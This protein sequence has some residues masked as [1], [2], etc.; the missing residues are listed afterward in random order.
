MLFLRR[1]IVC[2]IGD[3]LNIRCL[4]E[5]GFARQCDCL[6]GARR[7]L[8]FYI[9]NGLPHFSSPS[10]KIPQ[11]KLVFRVHAR[12]VLQ[13]IQS[14]LRIAPLQISSVF[15][16]TGGSQLFLDCLVGAVS[17]Q[18]D[19]KKK[20]LTIELPSQ[21]FY[22]YFFFLGWQKKSGWIIPMVEKCW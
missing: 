1:M 10:L 9:T 2:F 5:S 20:K 12:D 18:I 14:V 15:W 7:S 4:F 22:F 8:S 13:K 21:F 6:L 17:Q 3:T 11:M 19:K 16:Q